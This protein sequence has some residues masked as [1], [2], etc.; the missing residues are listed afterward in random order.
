MRAPTPHAQMNSSGEQCLATEAVRGLRKQHRP[1][2]EAEQPG[3][4]K[5]DSHR[6]ARAGQ[7]ALDNVRTAADDGIQV[8]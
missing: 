2:D 1:P 5:R 4:E 6:L 7:R 8:T 3:G